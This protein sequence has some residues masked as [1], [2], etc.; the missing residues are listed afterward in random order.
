MRFVC[1]H[2]IW[3]YF[4][5]KFGKMSQNLSVAA[6]GIATLRAKFIH[7]HPFQHAA[8]VAQTAWLL[9]IE[10][11]PRDPWFEPSDLFTNFGLWV[12]GSMGPTP[13]L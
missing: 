5:R 7:I 10:T 1:S 2:K 8:L 4:F 9:L 13:N 12:L 6:V 3:S 11:R